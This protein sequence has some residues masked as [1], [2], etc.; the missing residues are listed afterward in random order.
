[1]G[2]IEP[3]FTIIPTCLTKV[4]ESS[5]E[6]HSS[7]FGY[8]HLLL[9]HFK[10][11]LSYYYKIIRMTFLNAQILVTKRKSDNKRMNRSKYLWQLI[12]STYLNGHILSL[13][14]ERDI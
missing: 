2:I 11:Y 1:M 9:R 13:K 7:L 14:L 8:C 12:N 5:D 6:T 4:C 3:N 10:Q